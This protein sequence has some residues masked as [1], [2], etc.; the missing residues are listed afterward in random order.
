VQEPTHILAGV[1][2]QKC[3]DWRK[4]RA[5]GMALTA[6][7]AFLSH[8]LLD[9]LANFTYHPAHADFHSAIWVSYHTTVLLVTILFLVLWWKPYWWGILFA[10]L[11]DIDWVFIHGQEILHIKIPFYREPHLHNL[12]HWLYARVPAL[13]FLDHLPN[14]RENPWAILCEVV[15][16][17]VLLLIIRG[18]GKKKK[19]AT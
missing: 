16:V 9:K 8:G 3:F 14:N 12:L 4:L 18:S 2:I 5:V 6:M 1:I 15:L 7:L 13:S 17:A 19:E 11:P 10:M